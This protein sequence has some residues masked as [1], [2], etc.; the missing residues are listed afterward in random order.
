MEI[1]YS[2][3][4]LNPDV[5]FEVDGIR[6]H[7]VA[8]L[9][10]RFGRVKRARYYVYGEEEVDF[11]DL[12]KIADWG[13]DPALKPEF[14]RRNRIVVK[15]KRDVLNAGFEA[16]RGLAPEAISSKLSFSRKAGCNCGCSPGFV[17]EQRLIQMGGRTYQITDV[18]VKKAE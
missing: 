3:T 4:T 11:S 15:N 10:S 18:W 14:N 5:R 13:N 7:F 12:Y 17:G 1:T 6:I 9:H 8:E 16:M 2:P